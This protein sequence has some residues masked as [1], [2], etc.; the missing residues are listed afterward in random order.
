MALVPRGP[1]PV[2]AGSSTEVALNAAASSSSKAKAPGLPGSAAP[3]HPIPSQASSNDEG[4]PPY[5]P[6]HRTEPK[7]KHATLGPPSTSVFFHEEPTFP[8][9]PELRAQL[10]K[11]EPFVAPPRK[12]KPDELPPLGS[13]RLS[14]ISKA[15]SAQEML[16]SYKHKPKV[17]AHRHKPCGLPGYM[18]RLTPYSALFAAAN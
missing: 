10:P 5:I 18:Q 4:P 1:D 14:A 7:P 3:D 6:P 15:P 16:A 17:S 12:P 13:V 11:R 9:Y 8:S 2:A